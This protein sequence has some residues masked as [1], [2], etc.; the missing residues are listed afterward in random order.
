MKG[1]LKEYFKLLRFT[2]AYR[3]VLGLAFLC[4]G[5]STIFDGISIGMIVPVSD[6]ILT[7]KEIILPSHVPPFIV[8]LVNKLN[9]ISPLAVLKATVV[10]IIFLFLFKGF[11]IF[12]QTYL[13]NV[14]GQG[15]VKEVRN[16]LYKKFQDLSMEFYSKKRTGELISR[17][18]NDVSLITHAISSSLADLIYQSMQLVLFAFLVFYLYWKMALV[19]FVLFPFIM[20]PVLKIGKRI[21]KFSFEVQNKMADLNSLL[22][23]TIQGAYIVKVFN[24]EDYEL[25]RFNKLNYHYYK[26]ML[27]IIKRKEM[28]SPI[29]EFIGALGAVVILL[30]A[31]KEVIEG[32]LSFGIFGLFMGSLMSMIKPF[33]RLSRVHAENQHALAASSR[34]YDILEE[35][36]KIT[37]KYNAL[38]INEFKERIEFSN[39][40]FK[41][42][43]EEDFVLKDIKLEAKKGET[44][45]L[46]G[47]SGAGKST[48]VGLIPRLYDSQKGGVLIDGEDVRELKIKDLRSLIAVVSQDLVLFNATVRDNIA[49][50]REG[51]TQQEIEEAAKKA[52]AYDF[53]Q[54]LPQGFSTVIG[55]RGFRLSGGERQR[56]SIARAILRDAPI[57]ILDEATSQLDSSSEQLIKE[58]LY[59]LM[60]GK[61]TFVI[62]HRLSTVQKADKIVVME[63][64]RIAEE[65]DHASLI[66]RKSLYKKLY[67]LQFNV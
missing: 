56:I 6:R 64:G 1:Y 36:P 13:M 25:S 62:A 19:S 38:P 39:V 63:K 67:D 61:T 43:E 31:G 30:V 58:A 40:W 57:L 3:G 21:K 53:I 47:H 49:Y 12:M 17:I 11:F 54:K 29:T 26:F 7:N 27:K 35:E 55:D 44:I 16:S 46:V 32:K 22:A 14:A 52:F 37:E 41:Y 18:T 20:L 60:K 45:A 9:Q 65:G 42:N 34:I 24:R 48:M 28:L 33:K 15:V 10:V 8:N 51:A 50:G 5:F 2:K 59:N 23:E 66:S 4:M